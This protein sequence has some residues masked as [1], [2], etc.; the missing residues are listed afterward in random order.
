MWNGNGTKIDEIDSEACP[1]LCAWSLKKKKMD[2]NK[3]KRHSMERKNSWNV[4]EMKNKIKYRLVK[5]IERNNRLEVAGI[6]YARFSNVIAV[7]K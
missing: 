1:E 4:K 5:R 2:E 3:K 7:T 6:H